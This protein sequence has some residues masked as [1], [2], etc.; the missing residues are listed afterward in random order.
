M[1]WFILDVY[2]FPWYKDTVFDINGVYGDDLRKFWL[3]SVDI[4]EPEWY[5]IFW[6][7]VNRNYNLYIALSS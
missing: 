5:T 4:G 6:I 2:M 1:K 3:F 7:S